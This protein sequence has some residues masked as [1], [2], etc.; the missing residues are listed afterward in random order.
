MTRTFKSDLYHYLLSILM[1]TLTGLSIMLAVWL[2]TSCSTQVKNNNDLNIT[3][4]DGLERMIEQ[5]RAVLLAEREDIQIFVDSSEYPFQKNGLGMQIAIIENGRGQ[6]LDTGDVIKIK[7]KVMSLNG[8]E[9][10]NF[11]STEFSI[12]RDNK[13]IWGVQEAT[14]GSNRGDSLILVIPAHLA[15]GLAGDLNTIPPLTPLVYYLRIL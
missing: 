15:H 1:T 9:F 4:V 14:L 2:T 6:S 8:H 13:M 10:Y 3:N 7:S 11:D 5:N 12:L